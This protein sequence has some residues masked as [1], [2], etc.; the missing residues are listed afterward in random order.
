[1]IVFF[2]FHRR[3]RSQ[4]AEMAPYF[5]IMNTSSLNWRLNGGNRRSTSFRFFSDG[6]VHTIQSTVSSRRFP[7]PPPPLSSSLPPLLLY[8]CAISVSRCP[9]N[10]MR[11]WRTFHQRERLLSRNRRQSLIG[12]AWVRT[13]SPSFRV[14]FSTSFACHL[15][16]TIFRVK[17]RGGGGP[18][19]EFKV[20]NWNERDS[21]GFGDL[22]RVQ[23]FPQDGR[24]VLMR[25]K[26]RFSFF[27]F[28]KG[29]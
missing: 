6:K 2:H 3:S 14:A 16:E 21:K 15:D 11:R 4:R 23:A 12:K 22:W 27:L 19:S 9:F 7:P 10:A 24:K 17:R 28:V 25:I 29:R 8:L 1:M 5:L 18:G 20:R 26:G 13:M